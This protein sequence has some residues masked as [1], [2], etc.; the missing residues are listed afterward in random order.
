MERHTQSAEQAFEMLRKQ[1][2][3]QRKKVLDVARALLAGKKQA[4]S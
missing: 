1:A 3:L 2:R 4:G